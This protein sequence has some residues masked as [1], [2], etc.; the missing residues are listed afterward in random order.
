M[1]VHFKPFGAL[2][3]TGIKPSEFAYSTAR[4]K[5]TLNRGD[6]VIV[7][8]L[9]AYNIG[10]NRFSPF[11]EVKL[12]DIEQ[13]SYKEQISKMAKKLKEFR[14]ENESLKKGLKEYMDERKT[15]IQDLDEH[16]S[17]LEN[18]RDET[19]KLE[20]VNQ[21]LQ[22]ALDEAKKAKPTPKPRAKK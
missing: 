10:K 6:I 13:D 8:K 9:D 20:K 1:K 18:Q 3:Y 21:D 19:A 12:I 17:E 22:K 2:R 4:P 16:K 14:L 15:L 5:P 7:S 11:E